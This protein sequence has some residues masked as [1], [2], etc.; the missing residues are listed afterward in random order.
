MSLIAQGTELSFPVAKN[1]C[2]V[3]TRYLPDRSF[4][5]ARR[6]VTCEI[7]RRT[8]IFG[9]RFFGLPLIEPIMIDFFRKYSVGYPVAAIDQIESDNDGMLK[10]LTIL[11]RGFSSAAIESLYVAHCSPLSVL[12]R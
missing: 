6:A 7:N 10:V 12:M 3:A 11:K 2:V 1:V 9:Q 4:I 5:E 8:A